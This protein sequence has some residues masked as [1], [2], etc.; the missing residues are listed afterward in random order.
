MAE[1]DGLGPGSGASDGD[2]TEPAVRLLLAPGLGGLGGGLS[3]DLTLE[4]VVE[5]MVD[6]LLMTEA[7]ELSGRASNVVSTEG[8]DAARIARLEKAL[9][10]ILFHKL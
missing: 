8:L 2:V 10:T 7:R 5:A 6:E 1:A 3:G 4:R 9:R